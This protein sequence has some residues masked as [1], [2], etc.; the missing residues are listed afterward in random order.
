MMAPMNKIPFLLIV[1][2]LGA[3]SAKAS[4]GLLLIGYSLKQMGVGG[5]VTAN[6]MT[7]LTAIN[8]PAGLSF[9]DAQ[10]D[11]SIDFALLN[12]HAH[13]NAAAAYD[14][15]SLKKVQ[16]IP[17]LG[18]MAPTEN[19]RVRFGLGVAVVA[20][21]GTDFSWPALNRAASSDLQVV[22]IAPAGAYKIDDKT[23]VGAALHFNIGRASLAN[24]GFGASSLPSAFAHGAEMV[25]YGYGLG[26]MHDAVPS[27][28]QIGLSYQSGTNFPIAEY[29]SAS[30]IYKGDFDLPQQAALGAAYQAS[31]RLKLSGDL[32]WINY[33]DT[34]KKLMIYGPG[35]PSG[36]LDLGTNWK[37]Q[38]VMAFGAQYQLAEHLKVLAGYNHCSAPFDKSMMSKNLM[39]PAIARHHYTLGLTFESDNR[40]SLGLL[41]VYAPKQTLTDGTTTVSNETFTIGI[42][43]AVRF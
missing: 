38:Y 8:N 33:E 27:K 39:L 20:G 21:S 11:A 25:G 5:A 26:V 14:A 30:G 29:G 24:P 13:F 16:L 41:G 22:K 4:D 15:K 28:L 12:L 40:W 9:V 7:P 34:L 23:S 32:K 2:A 31:P 1:A 36:G 35:L 43:V 6:P 10:T 18:L 17:S 19:P 3:A 37:D 42:N